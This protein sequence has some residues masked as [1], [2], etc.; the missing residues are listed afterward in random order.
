METKV[1]CKVD[2]RSFRNEAEG[3]GQIG[4]YCP[5]FATIGDGEIE[6]YLGGAVSPGTVFKT[7]EKTL[8][9]GNIDCWFRTYD[10]DEDSMERWAAD[11]GLDP[12]DFNPANEF[13]Y[14]L[15]NWDN[16]GCEEQLKDA[17]KQFALSEGYDVVF[18]RPSEEKDYYL[19][20]DV[21]SKDMTN[22]FP[23]IFKTKEDAQRY[24]KDATVHTDDFRIISVNAND[25]L[26][27]Y[28]IR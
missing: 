26:F 13:E 11:T 28:N 12:E 8:W 22:C 17:I 21:K 6:V 14:D 3:Q 18:R 1:T 27:V 25:N 24:L 16:E 23:Y 7:D 2:Y 10:D 19:I 20:Q 5:I 9:V 15:D 4:W